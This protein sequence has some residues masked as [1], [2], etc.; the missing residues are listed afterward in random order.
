[1]HD[2]GEEQSSLLEK[3]RKMNNIPMLAQ[4]LKREIERFL[5]TE[6]GGDDVGEKE[7]KMYQELKFACGYIQEFLETQQMINRKFEVGKSYYDKYYNLRTVEKRTE[8][9]IWFKGAHGAARLNG[10]GYGDNNEYVSGV[11]DVQA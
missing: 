9:G 5:T 6:C 2:N 3:E 4:D 8:K 7:E 10:V 1:M 11:Y